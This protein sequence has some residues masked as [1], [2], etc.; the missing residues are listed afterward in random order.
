MKALLNA[1]V[2]A[3]LSGC[4]AVPMSEVPRHLFADAR[5]GPPAVPVT[6]DDLFDLSEPMR[7]FAD[8]EVRRAIER[9]GTYFGMFHTLKDQ[10]RL[11][12]DASGSRPA[13]Q[14]FESRAGNCISLVILTAAFAKHLGMPV[15]YQSVVGQSTWTRT[16]GIAFHSG[17]VNLKVGARDSALPAGRGSDGLTIDFLAAPMAASFGAHPVSE[18]TLIAMYLNN[19]AAEAVVEG[20]LDTAYWWGRAA[21]E[22]DP[23]FLAAANTL[24]VIYLRHG[25]AREAENIFHYTLLREPAN[26]KVITNLFQLYRRLG[27]DSEAAAM[28]RR[29]A[30]LEPFPPFY[31]LDQGQAALERGDAASALALFKR[32]LKRLPYNDEV[33]F[34]LALADYRLGELDKARKHLALAERYSTTRDRRSLYSA[35]LAHLQAQTAR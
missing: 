34:A 31:F 23:A 11:D 13:V 26:V 20:D 18:E 24:G 28:Q 5:F 19:R 29:L 33:H 12:Y 14:T 35:K 2:A 6:A 21:I 30:E 7:Q 3:A 16:A 15:Y 1:V 32:E 10:L 8:N 17:H 27:R 22:A 9:N 4:A 25:D